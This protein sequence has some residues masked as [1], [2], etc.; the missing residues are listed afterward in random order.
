MRRA[1]TETGVRC[2]PQNGS[3]LPPL[4]DN[5]DPD[6]LG[7][8]TVTELEGRNCRSNRAVT[9]AQTTRLL[10]GLMTDSFNS[11]RALLPVRSS[12]REQHSA[13]GWYIACN[14]VVNA[15]T[16]YA[17]QAR[18]TGNSQN[19]RVKNSS[20]WRSK[21]VPRIARKRKW[22][23]GHSHRGRQPGLVF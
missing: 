7:G 6:I 11:G 5:L 8:D 18:R 20:R 4:T 22:S 23:S 15:V 19:C 2:C 9:C 1:I 21:A 16:P 12:N 17:S 10:T 14:L 13:V 3:Q